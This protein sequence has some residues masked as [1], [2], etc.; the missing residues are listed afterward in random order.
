MLRSLLLMILL[1][2]HSIT[3]WARELRAKPRL[4]VM[5]GF[6]ANAREKVDTPSAGAFYLFIDRLEDGEYRKPCEH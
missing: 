4:A 1:K 2:H 5:S 3:N 6:A